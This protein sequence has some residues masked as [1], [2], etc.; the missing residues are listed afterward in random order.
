MLS[1]QSFYYII[2]FIKYLFI[3]IFLLCVFISQTRAERWHVQVKWVPDG[4]TLYLHSGERVR[5]RGIDAPEIGYENQIGQ[6][7]AQKSRH[8]LWNLVKGKELH[9]DTDNISSGRYGRIIACVWLP[10]GRLLNKVLLEQGMAFYLPYIKQE[11][12]L[13]DR[14]LRAQRQAMDHKLGFWAKLLALPVNNQIYIGN[15]RSKRFHSSECIYAQRISKKNRVEFSSLKEAF[16]AGFAPGSKCSPW[17][18]KDKF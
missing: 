5:L 7:H 13:K 11:E 6:F 2:S 18:N 14:L 9:I 16:Y 15:K 8:Y 10:D 17:P 12:N 3:V 1:R 4:D